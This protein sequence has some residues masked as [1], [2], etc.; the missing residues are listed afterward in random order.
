MR[1]V[2]LVKSLIAAAAIS[3]YRFVSFD[4]SDAYEVLQSSTVNSLPLGVSDL[5]ATTAA[6]PVDVILTGI[7]SVT[8]GGTVT[9]G[10]KVTSD[11]TGR[12]IAAADT[13]VSVAVAGSTAGDITV[14]GIL[15]TDTLV[16]VARLNR[17][18]TAATIELTTITSEFTIS[19]AN[20]INNAA[21]TNTTGDS[22]LVTYRRKDQVHGIAMISGVVGD[23]GS[24]LLRG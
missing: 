8:Y 15:T 21:G 5:G 20:T 9:Q 11:S 10:Q 22:L 18:A 1:N 16:S 6:D 13:L 12:A 3:A 23:V 19:A 24:V 2:G 14:T 4:G 7:A 17:D